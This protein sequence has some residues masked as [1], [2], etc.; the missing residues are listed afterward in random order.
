MDN[1]KIEIRY[2]V[3]I[4]LLTLLWL[5]VEFMVGLHDVYIAYHMYTNWLAL[6][7]PVVCIRMALNEKADQQNGRLS[8]KQGF[9]SGFMVAFFAAVLAVPVQVIF[10]KLIN[11]DYFDTMIQVAVNH[12]ENVKQNGMRAREEAALYYNLTSYIIQSGLL[13]LVFGTI[14]AAI[15]AWFAR[16]DD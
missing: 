13:M 4:S 12:A 9:G 15:S 14:V 8:F 16:N 11:P 7:I 1:L 2:A 3:L 10:H 6:L 5:S